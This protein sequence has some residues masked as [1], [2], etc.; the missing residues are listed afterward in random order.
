M[1][2]LPP[3]MAYYAAMTNNETMMRD[4]YSQCQLYRKYLYDDDVQLYKRES[5]SHPSVERSGSRELTS[6]P[7]NL[8]SAGQTFSL[9]R[10]SLMLDTGRPE[11]DGSLL[12]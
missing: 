7:R 10:A 4:A 2:M 1:Y 9:D 12:E 5:W 8:F 6:F 11:T 3:F